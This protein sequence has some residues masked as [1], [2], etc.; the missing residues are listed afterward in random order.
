M[1]VAATASRHT[2]PGLVAAIEHAAAQPAR[3]G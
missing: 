1:R 2:I 3:N